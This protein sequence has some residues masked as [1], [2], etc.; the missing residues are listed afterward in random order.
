[1]IGP[2]CCPVYGHPVYEEIPDE[3]WDGLKTEFGL[4]SLPEVRAGLDGRVA[5]PEPVMRQLIRVFIGDGTF[6]PGFQFLPGGGLR[7]SV[8]ELFR[9]AMELNIPHN[10]FVAWMITPLPGPGVRPVD[11][12]TRSDL[13]LVELEGFARRTAPPAARR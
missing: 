4:P 1:M 12:L 3:L 9:R 8:L 6:C 2:L 13:L 5:D 11:E 10:T 7:Q